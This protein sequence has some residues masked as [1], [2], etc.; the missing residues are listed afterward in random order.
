[1]SRA[2]LPIVIAVSTLLL[3]AHLRRGW[4][5]HDEGGLGESAEWV[6]EGGLPHRDFDELYTGY[7]TLAVEPDELITAVTV[8]I[9]DRAAVPFFRKVGTRRAQSI[10][11]M[12]F[13]GL[14]E[15][16][17]AGR[18]MLARLAFG[19][20]APVPLLAA[21]AEAALIGAIPSRRTASAARAAL[22]SDLSPIDDIRSERDYRL[23]VAGNVLEQF[24]R[25]A[26]SRFARG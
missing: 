6:L 20:M 18:V 2:W 21:G 1:M 13:C 12:V 4:I 11:K 3:T 26:D 16:E 22:A 25:A 7:R 5:P 15:A 9:P 8:P 14:L 19:S 24:L 10:S 23:A 17:S